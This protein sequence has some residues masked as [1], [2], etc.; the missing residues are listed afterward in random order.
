MFLFKFVGAEKLLQS[1]SSLM[2]CLLIYHEENKIFLCGPYKTPWISSS[3]SV[4]THWHWDYI[5]AVGNVDLFTFY[6]CSKLK[7][8]YLDTDIVVLVKCLAQH[9]FLHNS[10]SLKFVC[11]TCI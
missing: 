10:H 2:I 3:G 7:M 4:S 8:F 9:D 11:T 1:E 6:R 5:T